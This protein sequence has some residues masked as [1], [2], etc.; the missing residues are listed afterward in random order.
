MYSSCSFIDWGEL[1]PVFEGIPTP[2]GGP[3]GCCC[4]GGD[5]AGGDEYRGGLGVFL[6]DGESSR[7][8]KVMVSML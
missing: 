8:V 1:S 2:G 5:C 3:G 7:T 4:R 6:A